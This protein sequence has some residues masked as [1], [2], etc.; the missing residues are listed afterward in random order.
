MDVFPKM[1]IGQGT[2]WFMVFAQQHT[3]F[4]F[5]NTDGKCFEVM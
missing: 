3:K 4:T 5:Y 2:I 1:L